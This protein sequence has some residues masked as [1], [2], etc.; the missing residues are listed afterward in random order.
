MECRVCYETGGQFVNPCLCKGQNNIHEKCLRQ[1]IE[2]SKRNTCEICNTKYKQKIVFSWEIK[3]Y[4]KG[5]IQ[6]K[7]TTADITMM[8]STFAMTFFALLSIPPDD[9]LLLSSVVTSSMYLFVALFSLQGSEL[10]RWD[11]LLWWKMSYS[12]PL[13]INLFIIFLQNINECS[14][15]CYIVENECIPNCPYYQRMQTG[16]K[17]LEKNLFFDLANILFVLLCRAIFIFPKYNQKIV[18]I[19]FESFPESEPLL[20]I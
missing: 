15:S 12:V 13:F 18:F 3:K 11:S 5:C 16:N 7:A 8:F 6:C 9:F 19:N 10:F 14:L 2:T 4:L 20:D 17:L 1:W